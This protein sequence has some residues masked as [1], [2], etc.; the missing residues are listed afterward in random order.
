MGRIAKAKLRRQRRA[1]R[2]RRR[3][4]YADKI[5]IQKK[6]YLL[7]GIVCLF[8]AIGTTG[9]LAYYY[10]LQYSQESA[11]ESL[12][13]ENTTDST[14]AKTTTVTIINEDGEEEVVEVIIEEDSPYVSELELKYRYYEDLYDIEIP[15]LGIDFDKLQSETNSDIYAWIYIPGT[16][17]DYPI[18]QHATNN[19]YYLNYNIDGSYGRPGCIY[20]ENF[21][22]KSFTDY[23]TIIYG[24]NMRA[25]TMFGTL[26]RFRDSSFFYENQY[27]FIYLPDDIIVCKIFRAYRHTNQYLLYYWDMFSEEGYAEYLEY[28]KSYEDEMSVCDTKLMNSLTTS[29][30]IITLS[31]CVYGEEDKRYLVQAKILESPS[32]SVDL[33]QYLGE[34]EIL[35]GSEETLEDEEIEETEEAEETEEVESTELDAIIYN[36]DRYVGTLAMWTIDELPSDFEEIGTFAG[37]LTSERAERTSTIIFHKSARIYH[38]TDRSGYHYFCTLVDAETNTYVGIYQA[39]YN[40]WFPIAETHEISY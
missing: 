2:K 10:Y 32:S 23:N 13:A 19:T 38:Y 39:D 24:H 3:N 22:S 31:T 27:Y 25:E 34:D 33:T 7:A 18:L 30:R 12:R 17:V 11:Y 21:N 16:N 4:S 29:D 20:T 26:K 8:V 15:R 14:T 28:I 37:E 9:Y 5:A 1:N 36:G 6:L 35:I 40:E